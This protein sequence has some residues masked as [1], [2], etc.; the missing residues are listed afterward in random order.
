MKTTA[1]DLRFFSREILDTVSRGEEVIITYR[2]KPCARLVP[3]QAAK[4]DEYKE[5]LFGM[6][7]DNESVADVDGYIRRLRQGRFA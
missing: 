2:G 3:Y 6:W 7:Q 1:K 4:D 5:K